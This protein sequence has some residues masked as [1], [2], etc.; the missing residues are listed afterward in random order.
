MLT[1]RTPLPI[2]GPLLKDRRPPS[3][4]WLLV[5]FFVGMWGLATL[6]P[7]WA[8]TD[9]PPA[10]TISPGS[11]HSCALRADGTA[12]VAAYDSGLIMLGLTP[13][14][15]PLSGTQQVVRHNTVSGTV[16]GP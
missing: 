11:S 12:Y 15:N 1:F 16:S 14:D 5:P 3:W 10:L 9:T 4:K 6:V 13:K 7:G 8:Q 2:P